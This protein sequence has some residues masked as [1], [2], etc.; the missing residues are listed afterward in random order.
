MANVLQ[1]FVIK[2]E[3]VGNVLKYLEF[4]FLPFYYRILNPVESCFEE[5]LYMYSILQISHTM[6]GGLWSNAAEAAGDE[7]PATIQR[8]L[9]NRFSYIQSFY[10]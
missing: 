6:F 10:F 8:L 2:N 9:T 5:I 7:R 1:Y 4:G 3:Y